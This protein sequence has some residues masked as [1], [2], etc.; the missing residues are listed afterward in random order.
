MKNPAFENARS[1]ISGW[2]GRWYSIAG[3]HR[4]RYSETCAFRAGRTHVCEYADLWHPFISIKPNHARIVSSCNPAKIAHTR[5]FFLCV[6]CVL[7]AR[8]FAHAAPPKQAFEQA[9]TQLKFLAAGDLLYDRFPDRIIP[10]ED[11]E[12]HNKIVAE[13]FAR[14]DSFDDL[15]PLLKHEDPKVR[16]L[17]IAALNHQNNPKLLPL[18]LSLCNDST[19]TLPHPGLIAVIPGAEKDATPLE[20]QTVADFPKAILRQYLTAAGY[21]GGVKD[22]E[23]YWRIRK[24]R[25][26]CASWLKV[27]LDRATQR[28]HPIPATRAPQI[29]A[30]RNRI[31][32]L[33]EKDRQWTEL[34]LSIPDQTLLD[35]N[36]CFAAAKSLGPEALLE[37]L[38]G[39]CPSTD[40]DLHPRIGKSD[41]V[42]PINLWILQNAKELLRPQYA[43][44]LLKLET[45]P[46]EF[47][48]PFQ[49]LQSPWYAIAAAD[50][51]PERSREILTEAFK[52][53]GREGYTDA[54]ARADLAIAL[55]QQQG[56]VESQ[57]ITDWF[58]GETLK[59][60]GVPHSRCKF[61]MSLD[62]KSP[63]TRKLLAVLIADQRFNTLDWSS[64]KTLIP[65]INQ[66][67]TTPIISPD[68]LQSLQHPYGEQH[69]VQQPDQA[70]DLYPAQTKELNR[71]L[72]Q[73][74]EKVRASMSKWM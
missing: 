4:S 15:T 56:A 31:N 27:Q 34:Y 67:T 16:T 66:W 50:L 33:P 59:N 19:P 43:D 11:L 52:R 21:D 48:H 45:G 37:A 58:Y 74:R 70:A 64:L 7:C 41:P 24:D 2:H 18:L 38:R 32:Q 49:P 57:F 60:E 5:L 39:R 62:P 54:W 26:F 65:I 35:Q 28:T 51:T 23:E 63:S 17:A 10:R 73:W 68:E 40:P 72:E 61:L 29:E 53:F 55:W 14:T 71:V 36:A 22:F 13:L 46:H 20:P 12:S 44:I 9:A 69:V 1:P 25:P 6:L 8:T 42:N 30:L 3:C 47:A